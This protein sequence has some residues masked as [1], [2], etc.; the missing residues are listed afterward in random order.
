MLA[1]QSI[2]TID[3]YIHVITAPGGAGKL[4]PATI[5]KQMDAINDAYKSTNFQFKLVGVDT[6]VNRT[7]FNGVRINGKKEL[8]MKSATRKGSAATLNV[9]TVKL[10]GDNGFSCAHTRARGVE[11]QPG[12]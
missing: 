11:G 1:G 8:E 6:F 9:W 10:I 4:S 3:T 5:Q 2:T 7:W 12:S